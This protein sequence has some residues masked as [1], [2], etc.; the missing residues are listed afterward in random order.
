MAQRTKRRLSMAHTETDKLKNTKIFI[1]P[2]TKNVIDSVIEYANENSCEIGLIPS[3]RQ[4]EFDKGY[5]NNWS[6]QEFCEYVK[7][8]SKFVIIER[9][10]AGPGQGLFSDD[11]YDSLKEDCKHFDLIH[12]DPWKIYSS[13]EQGLEKT[14]EMIE[15]CYEINKNLQYEI[16]TEQSIRKFEIE[17][18]SSFISDLSATLDKNVFKKIKFLVIQSGTGLF[19]NTQVGSY[20]GKRLKKML[21]LAKNHGLLTKEHNGDYIDVEIIKEK[22]RLGLDAI[23]IAPEFGLIET[24]VYLDNIDDKSFDLFWELCYESQR[25]KKWV[26][27]KFNPKIQRKELVQI[28]G[29]Y[30]FSDPEFKKISDRFD[31]KENIKNKIKEKIKKLDF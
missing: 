20:D 22:F 29:H 4:I 9:D 26:D 14:K 19:A 21:L 16:L 12:I 10:H 18:I 23:N 24:Q 15:F 5:V 13:Y 6:T 25:W 30:V 27:E 1:G 28:C 8:N 11:G 7:K 17:E 2:V 31:L 3:R